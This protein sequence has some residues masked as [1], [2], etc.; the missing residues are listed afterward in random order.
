MIR[1]QDTEDGYC[2]WI[3]GVDVGVDRVAKYKISR[4]STFIITKLSKLKFYL[5][6]FLSIQ[7]SKR[8]T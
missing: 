2:A 4:N 7:P 8:N 6:S 1:E 3:K 5:L